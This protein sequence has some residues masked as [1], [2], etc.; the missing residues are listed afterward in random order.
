VISDCIGGRARTRA[1]TRKLQALVA[2]DDEEAGVADLRRRVRSVPRHLVF[3]SASRLLSFRCSK[4]Q[5]GVASPC[6]RARSC[7][8]SET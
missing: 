8:Q 4:R 5:H 1:R 7:W 6:P 2:E 3:L